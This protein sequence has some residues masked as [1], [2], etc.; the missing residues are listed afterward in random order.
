MGIALIV[1]SWLPV[2][3][4]ALAIMHDNGKL[5]S[6]HASQTFRLVVWGV[7]FMIGF[8]G[9]WLAG[10]VAIQTAKQSGWR[11]APKWL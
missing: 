10:S 8:V 3:Q 2:A 7:Q 1:V 6:D 4:V 5:T 9:L 11:A